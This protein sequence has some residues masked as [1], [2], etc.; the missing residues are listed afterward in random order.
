MAIT[1]RITD[2]E[3]EAAGVD[4]SDIGTPMGAAEEPKKDEIKIVFGPRFLKVKLNIRK[5]L[6]NNIVV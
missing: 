4:P 5:T 1:I 3:V 2:R 6:D